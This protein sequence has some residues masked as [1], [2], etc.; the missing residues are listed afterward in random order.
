VWLAI[1][2]QLDYSDEKIAAL[3]SQE[4]SENE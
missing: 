1:R 3:M 4:E 2:E